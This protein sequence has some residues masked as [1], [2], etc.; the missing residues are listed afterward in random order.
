MQTKDAATDNKSPDRLIATGVA[1]L[2][3]VLGG[4]LPRTRVYLLQGEPGTGK[5]TI[6]LQFLL[7]GRRRGEPGLY[8]TLSESRSELEAVAHSHG[9]SLEGTHLFE[10]QT[11]THEELGD[12]EQYDVFHPGE[13]ELGAVMRTLLAE[14]ERVRPARV[15]IDSL[16]ELRLLAREPIRYRRQLL[17]LKR[18]FV[19][20]GATVLLLDATHPSRPN[21]LQSNTLVHGVILLEQSMPDFGLKRRRLSVAKL[22]GVKYDDAYHDFRITTGGVEVY[23]RLVASEH[24]GG[25]AGD[26]IS[27]GL[28]ELDALVG[29]GL[30]RGTSTMLMGPAGAGKSS[31]L[32]QYMLAA[33]N[34][35][36]RVAL[37]TFDESIA[38]LLARTDGF[39]MGLG[40]HIDAGRLIV[41]QVDPGELSPGQFSNMVRDAVE[42]DGA[43]VIA[44]DSLNGYLNAAPEERFLMVQLHEL[45]TYLG[46]QRVCTLLTVAQHGL[47]G[48]GMQVPVDVSYLADSVLL[49]RYFEHAG[50]VRKAISVVK[51][52]VGPHE[53]TIRELEITNRGVMVG[54]P[55][56]QFRGVLTGVPVFLG[57][58]DGDGPSQ[59]ER[60][61]ADRE[62]GSR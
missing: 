55:L 42:R 59:A 40:K 58:A 4:G 32:S 18:Y 14:A 16:S 53:R 1:G 21:D 5:T 27:S 61:Q 2:D 54:R 48:A 8:V 51:K 38:T 50:H 12:D 6:S 37:Y 28:P 56:Q 17:A 15:V 60:G 57:G 52:R 44:I 34:R 29:G 43:N 23:P 39:G 22:R 13:V 10:A 3:T 31:L 19:S 45:F 35:G 11:E 20:R 30:I 26:L 49:F 24:P 62:T 9:W 33:C 36:E 25:G 46:Q 47:M 41:R 7:E